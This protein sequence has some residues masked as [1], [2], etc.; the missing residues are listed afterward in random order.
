MSI[1][2]FYACVPQPVLSCVHQATQVSSKWARYFT[3]RRKGEEIFL[4][5]WTVY[6]LQEKAPLVIDKSY[7]IVLCLSVLQFSFIRFFLGSL[8]C[9]S[10]SQRPLATAKTAQ[11]LCEKGELFKENKKIYD[12]ETVLLVC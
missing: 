6:S 11:E 2:R 1:S 4:K 10:L 12:N 8:S 5:K 7:S 9:F 3:T